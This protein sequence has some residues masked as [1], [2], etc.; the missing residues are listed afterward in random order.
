MKV[1]NSSIHICTVF[2][3]IS[4]LHENHTCTSTFSPLTLVLCQ[5]SHFTLH[6]ISNF[7]HCPLLH[8]FPSFS[9]T[10]RSGADLSGMCRAWLL[11]CWWWKQHNETQQFL[12]T[13][14]DKCIISLEQSGTFLA[15]SL[16]LL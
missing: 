7:Q 3:S 14:P 16:T 15:I 4:V 9:V 11:E 13:G 12:L 5:L 1:K 10:S 8:S 2:L 6:I